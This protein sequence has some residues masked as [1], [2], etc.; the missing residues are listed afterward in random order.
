M[1]CT[2]SR[3]GDVPPKIVDCPCA[4]AAAKILVCT[5]CNLP[6]SFKSINRNRNAAK[7]ANRPKP[8]V[9]KT[10]NPAHPVRSI[11]HT[12]APLYEYCVHFNSLHVLH[13]SRPGG[14]SRPVV[15]GLAWWSVCKSKKTPIGVITKNHT[16]EKRLWASWVVNGTWATK[17]ATKKRWAP[18]ICRSLHRREEVGC[19]LLVRRTTSVFSMH[20][21]CNEA[22][23][24]APRS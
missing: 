18:G 9:L 19:R 1:K 21:A 23:I 24:C 8:T 4:A 5:N 14:S 12:S 2:A 6:A 13:S 17:S 20:P 7:T 3:P 10:A 11:R 16:E 15:K 22:P